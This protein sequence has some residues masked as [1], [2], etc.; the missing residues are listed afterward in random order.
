MFEGIETKAVDG[1]LAAPKKME[2]TAVE[3]ELE[4][5]L[6]G[7]VHTQTHT[8]T[9]TH[10]CAHTHTH[11]PHTHSHAHTPAYKYKHMTVFPMKCL[12]S[13][14][15]HNLASALGLPCLAKKPEC[16]MV[17][18]CQE[19]ILQGRLF[20]HIP[21]RLWLQF[22]VLCVREPCMFSSPAQ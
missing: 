9:Y 11:T 18:V 5:E 2:M 7:R 12:H 21:F 10:A 20:A 22:V 16:C 8:H 13:S 17:C 6:V 1:R 14:I 19:C 4:E 3:V 15:P